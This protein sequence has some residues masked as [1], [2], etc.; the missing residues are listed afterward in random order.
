M[1]VLD[2]DK[3]HI[4]GWSVGSYIAEELTLVHSDK[5]KSLIL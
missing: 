3:A 2:I 1:G 5:V 4:V